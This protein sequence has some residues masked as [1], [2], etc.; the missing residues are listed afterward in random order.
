MIVMTCASK[1]VLVLLLHTS[2]MTKLGVKFG[3]K[4]WI[5]GRLPAVGMIAP[6]DWLIFLSESY[7]HQKIKAQ[8]S[9][10]WRWISI[11]TSIILLLLVL[12]FVIFSLGKR[13][14]LGALGMLILRTLGNLIA[15]WSIMAYQRMKSTIENANNIRQPGRGSL[16]NDL[17]DVRNLAPRRNRGAMN[18]HLLHFFK[19]SSIASATDNFSPAN[20]LG[21][22][23]FG[24][25]YKGKLLDG[26]E[27]A[28][29][30]L[31]GNSAQG[32][33][34]FKNELILIAKL[35][36]TNLVRLVGCCIHR[37]EKMLI[38][39]YMPNKSLDYFL[40][41]ASRKHVLD[42][43]KRF[44]IAEGIAQGL[45]YLHKYSRLRI[46]HRDLKAGNILL[47]QDMNPKISDFG[48]AKIFGN[49]QSRAN[50]NRVAGTFGYMPPEYAMEGVFS[51][52]SDVYSFGVML[53]E[54]VSGRMNNSFYTPDHP[55]TLTGYTWEMWK[56][57]REIEI[58]DAALR[59][60][61]E[62]EEEKDESY[63]QNEAVRCIQVGLLCVQENPDDRPTMMDVVAMISYE[64]IP[65][66][67]P[68]QPAFFVSR[69]SSS[70]S[71]YSDGASS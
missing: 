35:Q 60:E 42:W 38:Y 49:H 44:R 58:I 34:E 69:G 64:T 15:M 26:S 56:E 1:V 62:E 16:R 51:M 39:E 4:I 53:L 8:E 68:K 7:C 19:F 31:A 6:P 29:K 55:L 33:V 67:S 66:S 22:G 48:M 23:G 13:F 2:I 61:E 28:I 17:E 45:L 30:R 37:D 63:N 20:K 46:I 65:L 21:E 43:E 32:T 5:S 57:G 18:S 40:F 50:T 24:S 71:S 14:R 3:M 10:L 70:S 52:K 36:H 41:D 11:G 27:V 59:G 25:V 54:I 47:D 12:C 9:S